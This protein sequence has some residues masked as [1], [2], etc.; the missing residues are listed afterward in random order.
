MPTPT[1]VTI[2]V[3]Y[4]NDASARDDGLKAAWGF[5]CL[6]EKGDK[7]L[8]FDTGWDGDRLFDN[9]RRLGAALEST[10]S[11]V[12]SHL[13]WDHLGGLARVLGVIGDATVF[14]P[15]SF[16]KH[17]KQEIAARATLVE[18]SSPRAVGPGIFSTGEIDGGV[19]REQSLVVEVSGGLLVVT[20]CA[21]PGLGK[22]LD[23]AAS[24]GEIT[25]VIGGFH[26]FEE[27]DRLAP[28]KRI[29]PCHCTAK[30][31]AILAR[32]P[33]TARRG[34]VGFTLDLG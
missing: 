9:A 14:V 6:V 8:L 17:L 1:R 18:V 5:S 16:S 2:T 13:H 10:T 21:H 22:I 33:T 20:G 27:L 31:D 11:I 29:V 3:L 19:V 28:L 7:R 30:K 15:A 23:L 32:F 25:A 4:D 24:R 26:G 34:R 12:I